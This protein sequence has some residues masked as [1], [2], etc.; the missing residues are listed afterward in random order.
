MTGTSRV[1]RAGDGLPARHPLFMG[2]VLGVL[3]IWA[4]L[5]LLF[6]VDPV[7]RPP[8]TLVAILRHEWEFVRD[9]AGRIW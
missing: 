7:G 2:F 5:T 3:T 1:R 6:W 8:E 9:L 4:T